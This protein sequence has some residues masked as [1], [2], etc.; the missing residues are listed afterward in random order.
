MLLRG[1]SSKD[2]DDTSAVLR[3]LQYSDIMFSHKILL[4]EEPDKCLSLALFSSCLNSR[5]S[6][7]FDKNSVLNLMFSYPSF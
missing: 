6:I 3:I 4:S 2:Q 1:N 7:L 5:V